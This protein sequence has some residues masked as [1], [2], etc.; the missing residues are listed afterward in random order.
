MK[1]TLGGAVLWIALEDAPGDNLSA[2]DLS[3][4]LTVALVADLFGV[5][6]QRVAE[7]VWRLRN[8]GVWPTEFR[9]VASAMRRAGY[10][11]A[12][13]SEAHRSGLLSSLGE[14]GE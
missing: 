4:T 9:A 13:I 6:S 3:G 2:A 1:P 12:S 14:Q 11:D 5:T 7:M 8:G 10:S